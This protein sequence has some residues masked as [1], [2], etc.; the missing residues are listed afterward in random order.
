MQRAKPQIQDRHFVV[1]HRI[2][3]CIS[4]TSTSRVPGVGFMVRVVGLGSQGPEFKCC[5]AVEFIPGGAISAY[6]PSKVGKNECQ[7]SAILCRSGDPSRIVPN[8][9]G[10]CV[11]STNALH[12]MVPMDEWMD[13]PHASC[14]FSFP[15]LSLFSPYWV[16]ARLP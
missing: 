8:R 9:Q 3:G 11:G 10:E 12:S 15:F 2:N 4:F 14:N 5:S 1:Y 7:L 16:V 13:G 6:H